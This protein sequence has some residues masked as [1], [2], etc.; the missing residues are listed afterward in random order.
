[1]R[2]IVM[3]KVDAHMEAGE[4]PSPQIIQNMGALVQRSLKEGTFTNGAG[5]HRSALRARLECQGGRCTVTHGPYSGKNELVASFTMIRATSLEEAVGRAR[6]LGEALGD[7]EIEVG[8]VVE[9]WDLGLIPKPTGNVPGRFLLLH[10]ADRETESGVGSPRRQAALRQFT[11]SMR[12]QDALLMADSLAPS[13]RGARSASA[14][15]GAKRSWVDGPFAESKELIAGFSILEVPDRAAA[16]A[17]ADTYAA[18]LDGNEVDVREL[19]AA[20]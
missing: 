20:E 6:Q 7:A 1:M 13:V 16:L 12:E 9:P 18:I 15:K 4:P 17:W 5:L 19:H 2:F 10:K 3:H 11:E 14:K 8:P